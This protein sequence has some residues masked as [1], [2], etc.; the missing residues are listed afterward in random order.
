MVTIQDIA[1]QSGVSIGTV[2]RVLNSKPDVSPKTR[3]RIL[4]VMR[5][6]DYR[7][8][9]IARQL[10][11]KKSRVIGFLASDMMNPNFPELA[12][13]VVDEARQH[14]YS[15]MFFDTRRNSEFEQ[16]ATQILETENV[17]GVVAPIQ[18]KISHD[19]ARLYSQ[20]IPVVRIYQDE[21]SLTTPI[22]SLDNVEAGKAATQ[23]LLDLGHQD[24]GFIW[25][26]PSSFSDSERL[27]GYRLA[28]EKANRPIKEEL[29][30]DGPEG[31]ESGKHCME[32]LLNL[33]T[34]PTAV[35]ASKDVL[36]IGAYDAIIDSGKSIP[37][38]ISVLGH[39]D[40]EACRLVRPQ[41]ST[42][43]TNRHKLGEAAVQMLLQQIDGDAEMEQERIFTA[44][45]IVRESTSPL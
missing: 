40:I 13:G 20:K 17:A 41:M 39:D 18:K 45:L 32:K 16:E 5:E 25:R 37:Q 7:P 44:E 22:V 14:G 10:A 33:H 24:I 3:E 26:G 12:R 31:R 6:M 34:P 1:E 11:Q 30:V 42:M 2:S 28:L 43:T 29:I 21:S 9:G 8:N 36:A 38:D 4:E 15:V 23:H 35:F 19:L 27:K